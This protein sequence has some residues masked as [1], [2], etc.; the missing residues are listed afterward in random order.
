[1][2]ESQVKT[3]TATAKICADYKTPELTVVNNKVDCTQY[4]GNVKKYHI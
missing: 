1:M 3:V 2:L 4:V